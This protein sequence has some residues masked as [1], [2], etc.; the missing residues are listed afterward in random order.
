MINKTKLGEF[1]NISIFNDEYILVERNGL[2]NLIDNNGDYVS[3]TWYKNITKNNGGGADFVEVKNEHKVQ[4]RSVPLIRTYGQMRTAL[5]NTSIL[6]RIDTRCIAIVTPYHAFSTTTRREVIIIAKVTIFGKELLLGKNGKLYEKD[7]NS[8]KEYN[9]PTF[10]IS[11]TDINRLV[12][13]ADKFNRTYNS[14]Y[15]VN[16]KGNNDV[17]YLQETKTSCWIFGFD[18]SGSME[19]NSSVKSIIFKS[20]VTAWGGD[21][22]KVRLDLDMIPT[23]YHNKLISLLKDKKYIKWEKKDKPHNWYTKEY[24]LS[25]LNLLF[26]EVAIL[27]N[28]DNYLG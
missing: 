24:T 21:T 10:F 26:D 23:I 2:F 19:F 9:L 18:N 5:N 4:L 27:L 11:L 22:I 14:N 17:K 1:D 3:K 6:D 20:S 13:I 25:D 7:N 28:K 12:D 8:V 16:S 15:D